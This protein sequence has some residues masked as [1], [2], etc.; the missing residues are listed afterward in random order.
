MKKYLA[1]LLALGIVL[2]GCQ[3]NTENEKAISL[4]DAEKIA[5]EDVNGEI[6]KSQEEIDDGHKK[7]EINIIKDNVKYEFEIDRA[8]NI[9]SKDS[10]TIDTHNNNDAYISIDEA[11]KIALESVGG[12]TIIK[13]EL[14]DDDGRMIY[15]I[16]IMKDNMEYDVKIDAISGEVISSHQDF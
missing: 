11:N 3:S 9:I 8:G 5:L 2:G 13:N 7:F 4:K 12:G 14:D 6:V 15:E 1:T 10:E 16:E